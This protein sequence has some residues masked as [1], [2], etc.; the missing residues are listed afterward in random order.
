M[1]NFHNNQLNISLINKLF[2]LYKNT[3]Q[4]FKHWPK[5]ERYTLGQ[6]IENLIINLMTETFTINQLPTPLR[7]EKL[8]RL[9]SENEV[10]K[11]LFRLA[12]EIKILDSKEYLL[13][14]NQSQEIGKMIGGWIKYLKTLR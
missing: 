3:Y 11:L 9:N 12:Y 14:E 7:E 4:I 1:E 6:K 2:G 13:L 10:S 8:L 5:K